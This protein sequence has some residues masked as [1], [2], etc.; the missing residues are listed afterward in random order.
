M[1]RRRFQPAIQAV[2]LPQV[3]GSVYE[4]CSFEIEH[5]IEF[6]WPSRRS[7]VET[8]ESVAGRVVVVNPVSVS[9]LKEFF[10]IQLRPLMQWTWSIAFSSISCRWLW[11]QLFSKRILL[12]APTGILKMD[13]TEPL[14][15]HY[16]R[17]DFHV[18]HVPLVLPCETAACVGRCFL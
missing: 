9:L 1:L 5:E 10:G 4:S 3:G 7:L 6:D 16:V 13:S 18:L 12:K 15:L 8:A 17:L 11:Q 14:E 2:L